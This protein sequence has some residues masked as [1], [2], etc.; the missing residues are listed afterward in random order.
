MRDLKKWKNIN[1]HPIVIVLLII[2]F[3]LYTGLLEFIQ[4]FLMWSQINLLSSIR[5]T[6]GRQ[7][8]FKVSSHFEGQNILES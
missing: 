3:L 1:T 2:T 6:G 5:L 7:I 8:D 4:I